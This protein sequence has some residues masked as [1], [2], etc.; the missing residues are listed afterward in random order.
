MANSVKIAFNTSNNYIKQIYC[1][2]K[3]YK[4]KKKRAF[5]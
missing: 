3:N 1:S 4:K 5:S 2:I